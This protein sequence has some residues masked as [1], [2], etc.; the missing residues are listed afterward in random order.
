MTDGDND[1]DNDNDIFTT[2]L[3]LFSGS[4]YR[5]KKKRGV[6]EE[7]DEEGGTEEEVQKGGVESVLWK[8]INA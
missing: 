5:E 1:N 7:K 2:N 6:S 8:F 3:L 4:D